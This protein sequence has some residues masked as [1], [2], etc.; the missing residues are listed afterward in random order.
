[1]G[2]NFLGC[3][4]NQTRVSHP[5]RPSGSQSGGEKRR[6]ESFQA[7]TDCPRGSE[8]GV[9]KQDT[10]IENGSKPAKCRRISGRRF[11]PFEK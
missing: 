9:S 7:Q 11:S 8:D 6:D 2:V 1:M 5:R 10:F 3:A 4:I